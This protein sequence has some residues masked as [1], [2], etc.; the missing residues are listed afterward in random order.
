MCNL[1]SLI[2]IGKS[3]I[4]L[5]MKNQLVINILQY[6]SYIVLITYYIV[7]QYLIFYRDHILSTPLKLS[8]NKLR[9]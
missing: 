8:K 4:D 6:S 3:L 5:P 1:P 2:F 7:V 9:P